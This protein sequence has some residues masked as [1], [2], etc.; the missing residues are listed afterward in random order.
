MSSEGD[1]HCHSNRSD[2]TRSPADLVAMAAAHGVRVFALT[3]HD[4]LDGLDEAR[5]AV[6]AHPGMAFVP[7]VEFGCYEPGTE[8]HILGLFVDPTDD[9]FR[10]EIAEA[11]RMRIERGEAIT[12]ALASL[13]V[14]VSWGRVREIAGEAS[15]GRP[16]FARALIEAGHVADVDEAF[17]RYLGRNSPA[18]IEGKRLYPQEAIELIHGAGG[19]AVFAHPPFTA[20]YERIAEG[21]AG[22]GLDGI[23][24]YYRHYEPE[25]VESLRALAERLDLVPSGGSDFHGLERE[26]EHEP[27]HFDMPREAV[28]R[29]L[30]VARERGCANVPDIDLTSAP[31]TEA[32]A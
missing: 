17:A 2:G 9:A 25:V 6:A 23:E 8:V 5:A 29:L 19:L 18:Y 24:V 22:M 3:D 30:E 4:T 27:G 11:H 7:G 28:A 14:P 13:G 1:F 12:A 15:V 21:L 32:R 10:T 31:G 20:D 26:H 16:H